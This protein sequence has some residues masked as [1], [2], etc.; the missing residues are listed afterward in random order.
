MIAYSRFAFKPGLIAELGP[1]NFY[2]WNETDPLQ[3]RGTVYGYVI[4]GP[5]SVVD[6]EGVMTLRSGMYFSSAGP[7]TIAGGRGIAI[8]R[9][10]HFGMR[11][12]G[13]PVEGQGRLK[14]IDGCTDSL[15]IPPVKCGDPCLNL[16]QFPPGIDQT[17]HTHP[18]NR[19]GMILSG[20]GECH[21]W[22]SDVRSRTIYDDVPIR[23]PLR[24]RDLF[25]IHAE[26][27]HKFRTYEG[28]EMRVLAY[29][30]DSDYGPTDE[31]HPMLNRT[32]IDGASA[33]NPERAE[34]RTR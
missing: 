27:K 21:A 20:Q 28:Q 29:H 4:S 32:I 22:Q 8:R 15:L 19:I 30:P 16:L 10:D 18:S 26:G 3:L 24:A 33:A 9:L 5:T 13:G 11:L 17:A 2:A 6:L 31:D 12:F 7:L 23:Y 14:Y 34:Y 1:D 25:C